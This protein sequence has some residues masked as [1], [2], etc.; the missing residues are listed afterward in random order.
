MF[1]R[2]F[3]DAQFYAQSI[4]LDLLH[5][6]LEFPRNIRTSSENFFSLSHLTNL[7]VNR[8]ITR[9]RLF[10]FYNLLNSIMFFGITSSSTFAP[11]KM[12]ANFEITQSRRLFN[13][14]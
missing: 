6:T 13:V 4:Q 10:R 11:H 7:V 3:Y 9:M 14:K 1:C 5:G 12:K 2:I 8:S